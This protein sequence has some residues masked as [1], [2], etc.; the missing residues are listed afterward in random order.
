MRGVERDK[1][2]EKS[3]KPPA[4]GSTGQS[5]SKQPLWYPRSH[6]RGGRGQSRSQMTSFPCVICGGNHKSSDCSQRDGRCFRCGQARHMSWDCPGGASPTSS[7]TLAKYAPRQLAGLPP[8]MSAGRASAPRQPEGSRASSG[9]VF[10]TQVE[11]QSAV[12]E[13]V[14]AGIILINGI[15]ARALFETGASHS[16]IGASFAKTHGMEIVHNY[17]YWWVN[18]PEHLFRVHEQCL[19]CPVQIGEWIMPAN[20]LVL[21]QMWRFDL[22]LGVNWL[23]KYYASI[24]CDSKVI[25]F[26]EP[27][28]EEL[29]YQECKSSRFA[30]TVSAPRARKMIKSGCK[31]YLA[32]IVDA[33]KEH[34]K[35]GNI[36][37]ACASWCLSMTC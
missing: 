4:C 10:A 14:V 25:T 17:D 34:P 37:I 21:K 8:A 15:R 9:R 13:D 18:A 1:D 23:S 35:L 32:T 12:P 30:V 33:Q 2:K 19:A 31:A 6:W 29:V 27:G 3:K 22:I 11:E 5:S 16:F 24:D 7:A 26:R 28:Q 20:L 36:R